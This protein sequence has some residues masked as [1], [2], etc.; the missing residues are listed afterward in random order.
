M[1]LAAF[2]S[3][4]AGAASPVSADSAALD[5]SQFVREKPDGSWTDHQGPFD[6]EFFSGFKKTDNGFAYKF[7]QEGTGEKPVKGQ[8][9]LMRYTGYTMDGKRFDSSYDRGDN[10]KFRLGQGK[11]IAGWEAVVAGMSKEQRVI[12]KIP[13]QY[14]YGSKGVGPIKPNS[15]LVFYLELYRLYPVGE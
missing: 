2:S 12:V 4:L 10:F 7:V 15:D 11:V 9:V 13:A 6:D 1:A 14:A 5:L 3:V 8:A